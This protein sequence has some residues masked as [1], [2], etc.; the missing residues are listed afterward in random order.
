MLVNL[1]AMKRLH[2]SVKNLSR[3]RQ[4]VLFGSLIALFSVLMPWHTIGIVQLGA[5]N[6][7]NYNGFQDQNLIIGLIVFLL[8]LGSLLL[9]GLP[10]LGMR[11]PRTA[12]KDSSLLLFAGGQSVLLVFV[13][14]VMYMTSF[15]RVSSYDLRLGIYLT[16]IG[17]A[18]VFIG[19]YLLRIEENSPGHVRQDPLV[20]P[21]RQHNLH[22]P[23]YLDL[24]NRE[25]GGADAENSKE[26]AR[27]K[28]DI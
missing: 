5:D 2:H 1:L 13:L 14:M 19:G 15:A 22:D 26:D 10:L 18:L 4:T 17:A 24:S 7:H 23:N 28:L 12:W 20:R 16:L 21:P 11:S 6:V 3:S 25:S 8:M 9:V 27:M